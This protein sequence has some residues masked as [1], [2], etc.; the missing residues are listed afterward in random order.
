MNG[1]GIT[2]VG[3]FL[4]PLA[5]ILGVLWIKVAS[6]Q[7]GLSSGFKVNNVD[8]RKEGMQASS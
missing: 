3:G 6:W 1:A 2:V 5:P 7:L 8:G 4:L